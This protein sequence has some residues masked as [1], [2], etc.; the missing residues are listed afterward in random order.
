MANI[1]GKSADRGSESKS[2]KERVV[3]K[4]KLAQ[5]RIGH[6]MRNPRRPYD[7]IHCGGCAFQVR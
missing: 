4:G 7:I 5:V 1:K 6:V 2:R 3:L